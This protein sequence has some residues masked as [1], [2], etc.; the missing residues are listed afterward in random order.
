[1]K[2]CGE[3]TLLVVMSARISTSTASTRASPDDAIAARRRQTSRYA[4]A[5][6]SGVTNPE[7]A[8]TNSTPGATRLCD[9][10]LSTWVAQPAPRSCPT[11]MGVPSTLSICSGLSM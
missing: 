11:S 4:P 6:A 1:M 8:A 10:W 3:S 9:P 2:N 7:A 5:T